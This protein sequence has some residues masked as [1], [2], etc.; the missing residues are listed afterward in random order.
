LGSRIVVEK[1]EKSVKEYTW[2][3]TPCIRCG[4]SMGEEV[5]PCYFCGYGLVA[6]QIE[7]CPTCKFEPC[8]RCGKCFCNASLIEQVVLRVLRNKYCCTPEYFR[9]GFQWRIDKWLLEYVPHFVDALDNCRKIK[10]LVK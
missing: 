1:V 10:R 2:G 4:E 3:G 5:H 9:A 7:V 8:P 6:S